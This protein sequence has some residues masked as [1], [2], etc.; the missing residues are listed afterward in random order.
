MNDKNL[1]YLLNEFNE[2]IQMLQEAAG[3][4]N[5]TSFEEYRFTCGQIRG[6]EAAC[7]IIMDLSNRMESSD[8]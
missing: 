7:M 6:L 3:A 4:G 5:C 2:R 8:D 1:E